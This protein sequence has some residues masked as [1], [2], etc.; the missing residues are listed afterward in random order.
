[1]ASTTY[2]PQTRTHITPLGEVHEYR[3]NKFGNKC[4]DCGV[5]VPGDQG[6]LT[7]S[8]QAG[9]KV[10]HL[11][12]MCP[13]KTEQPAPQVAV[14]AETLPHGGIAYSAAS[15]LPALP[16]KPYQPPAPKIVQVTVGVFKCGS[17]IYVVKPAWKGATKLYAWR[18]VE[19]APRK[20]LAGTVIP[21]RLV[22]AYGA[23]YKL[24]E[25]MRLT[26]ADANEISAKYGKCICCARA[27]YAADTITK[28]EQTG[29]WVGPDCRKAYF[30]QSV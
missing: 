30:P 14:Q 17:D 12:G 16:A 19:S 10:R 11:P 25:D 21:F 28:C 23:I 4:A 9:W 29:I 6:E 22:K 24:T 13:E 7:G 18:L 20:T 15:T 8:K 2:A 27:L 1:M 5:Y 3:P 26:M